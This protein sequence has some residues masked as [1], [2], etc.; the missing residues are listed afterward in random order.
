MKKSVSISIVLVALS[1]LFQY[2]ASSDKYAVL[3][4]VTGPIKTNCYLLYD[5][6]SKEAALIDVGG[7]ID[8]HTNFI[9][10]NNLKLKYIFATHC[11]MEH[12]EGVPAIKEKFPDA[13]VCY[14][15]KE[16]EDLQ[17]FREW[18][19]E[20]MSPEELAQMKQ[21]PEIAKWFEYDLS[22]FRKPD[23]YLEDNQVYRLGNQKIKTI[24]SP[25]NSRGGICFYL[26]KALF[27][28]DVLSY[29]S[30]GRT[31]LL[32]GSSTDLFHSVQK[33]YRSLPDQTIVYPGHGQFT[34][35]GS[36]KI[37]NERISWR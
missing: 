26:G 33:L 29:R 8:A 12:I 31:D 24:L 13:L 9:I 30:A 25:G 17:V 20:N 10:E 36:E 27:S 21:N 6:K 5:L 2:C 3:H 7:P 19:K 28:G 23:I 32:G 4:E 1:L 37:E 11:H 14:N 18:I 15:K 35:I 16:Y 22:L 34:D